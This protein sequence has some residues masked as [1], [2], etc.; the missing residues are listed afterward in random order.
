LPVCA[1]ALY[2]SQQFVSKYIWRFF[3]MKKMKEFHEWLFGP[4]QESK[5]VQK[6]LISL[7]QMR[8]ADIE[9]VAEFQPWYIWGENASVSLA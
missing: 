1:E 8:H 4:M 9:K 3:T 6:H 5:T 2:Q 7:T